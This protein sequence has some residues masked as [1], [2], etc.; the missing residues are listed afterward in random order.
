MCRWLWIGFVLSVLSRFGRMELERERH[1]EAG[2]RHSQLRTGY[3]HIQF[4]HLFIWSGHCVS[5]DFAHILNQHLCV[6]GS[7]NCGE[8]E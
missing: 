4:G 2:K 6:F 7:D 3:M 5:A 8:T 1:A